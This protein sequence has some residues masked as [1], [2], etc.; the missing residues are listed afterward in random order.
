LAEAILA[1]AARTTDK[2][3]APW[4]VYHATGAGTT[5]W[6]EF[7]RAIVHGAGR[8]GIAP[9]PVLPITTAEFPT[10]AKRPANSCLDCSKLEQT[11]GVR[12]PHWQD[13]LQACIAELA[14]AAQSS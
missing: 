12:L 1:I 2:H 9:V 4:G 6:Y 13:G 3:P 5:S 10:P 14:G 7:A 8:L 11:F